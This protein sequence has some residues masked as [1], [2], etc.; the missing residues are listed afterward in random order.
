M[1]QRFEPNPEKAGNLPL[2]EMTE[3]AKDITSA[4]AILLARRVIHP[5][6]LREIWDITSLTLPNLRTD[7]TARP[8]M[9]SQ[10]LPV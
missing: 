6:I 3:N 8:G 1:S 4:F 5:V 7:N 9:K 10:E 2:L